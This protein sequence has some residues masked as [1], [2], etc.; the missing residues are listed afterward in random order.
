MDEP[1]PK[2]N[3]VIVVVAVVLLAFFGFL[4]MIYY[5]SRGVVPP[6]MIFGPPPGMYMPKI[7]SAPTPASEVSAPAASP[8]AVEDAASI[9]N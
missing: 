3:T 6:P 9:P 8:S 2:N 1:K 5:Q 7:G 4:A